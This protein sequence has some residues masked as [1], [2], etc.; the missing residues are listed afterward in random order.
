[1]AK[2]IN[3]SHRENL[4][5]KVKTDI[6]IPTYMRDFVDDAINL[7]M[8]PNCK[9]PLP[10][11]DDS[12]ASFRYKVGQNFWRCFGCGAGGTVVDLHL[13][14][15]DFLEIAA[16]KLR[17]YDKKDRQQR[18]KSLAYELA[19]EDFLKKVAPLYGIKN[20]TQYYLEETESTSELVSR[21]RRQFERASQTG[22]RS[23]DG[24]LTHKSFISLLEATILPNLKIRN[25][26]LYAD[27][28]EKVDRLWTAPEDE[29]NKIIAEIKEMIGVDIT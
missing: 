14:M 28:C 2:K 26:D 5:E 12:T 11:H 22:L 27:V 25:I 15:G 13:H 10:S 8:N 20:E 21:I 18:I 29:K 6:P 1:M 3:F 17:N 16:L 7:E 19:F 24:M 23:F 9:C 4:K